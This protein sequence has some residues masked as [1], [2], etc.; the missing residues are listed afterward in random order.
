MRPRLYAIADV[1]VLAAWG[2]SLEEFARGLRAAGVTL[3]QYRNKTGSPEEVLRAAAVLR[4]V[5]AGTACRLILNDRADLALLAELDGVHVGH[6]DLLPEDARRVA[7]A[8]R[9]VGV[10]THTEAQIRAADASCADYLAIGPVFATA[11]KADTEPVVGLEGVRRARALTTKP[12][13]AIGGITR[14]NA[15]SAIEAG[16]DSVAVISGLLADGEGVEQVARDFLE[17]LR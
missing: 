17:L 15:R 11:T 4:D 1:G 5:F 14:A 16:A 13:V 8:E 6:G 2:I 9:I 12:L 3:V 7:G 10:S